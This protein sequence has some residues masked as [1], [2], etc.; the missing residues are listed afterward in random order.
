MRTL[1]YISG[2]RGCGNLNVSLQVYITYICQMN[3]EYFQYINYITNVPPLVMDEWWNTTWP[4]NVGQYDRNT[5][6]I[7]KNIGNSVNG[8]KIVGLF[9]STHFDLYLRGQRSRWPK[10]GF[11]SLDHLYMSDEPWIVPIYQ[12]QH[13]RATIVD[14][15]HTTHDT[16]TTDSLKDQVNQNRVGSGHPR[17]SFLGPASFFLFHL[18][19]HLWCLEMVWHSA[20]FM[21]VHGRKSACMTR[22][23]HDTRTT[24]RWR[25]WFSSWS[26]R[27]G[28]P[29]IG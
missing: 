8:G 12:L 17:A 1:T 26:Q 23:T 21:V 11:A 20:V 19:F 14:D 16:R 22:C 13:E 7:G 10:S 9:E 15:G 27:P 3:H 28:E 18:Y 6:K 5:S 24:D 2:V 4:S 25:V 29:E